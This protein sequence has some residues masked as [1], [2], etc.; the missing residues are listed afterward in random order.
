M[1]FYDET[2]PLYIEIDASEFNW[3]L[4]YYRQEVVKL[5]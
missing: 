4:P 1:K 2:M 5:S 3:E